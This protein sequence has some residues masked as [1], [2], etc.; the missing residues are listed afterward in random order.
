MTTTHT[1]TNK[2][3]GHVHAVLLLKI[4][5]RHWHFTLKP[6]VKLSKGI[7][8]GFLRLSGALSKVR[9]NSLTV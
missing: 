3:L 8:V 2:V 5:Y 9:N 7:S 1:I 4:K 6:L